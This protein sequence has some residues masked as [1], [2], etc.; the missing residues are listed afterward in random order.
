MLV[1]K[2]SLPQ[3]LLSVLQLNE[4]SSHPKT[5]NTLPF[6]EM[7]RPPAVQVVNG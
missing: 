7:L 4:I 5:W 3:A 2:L 6:P 1:G